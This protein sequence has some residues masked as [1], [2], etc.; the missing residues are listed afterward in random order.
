MN[1]TLRILAGLTVATTLAGCAETAAVVEDP[2]G[3]DCREMGVGT[4]NV[5]FED[6]SATPINFDIFGNQN[7]TVEAGGV[8]FRCTITEDGIIETFTRV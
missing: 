7:Y 1:R 4:M 5:A 6:T 3:F 8:T 2:G